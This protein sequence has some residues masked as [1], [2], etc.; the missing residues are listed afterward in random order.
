M[1]EVFGE[2]AAVGRIGGDEYL[3]Y[4]YG[5]HDDE[6]AKRLAAEVCQNL[7]KHFENKNYSV[8]S[9]IGVSVARKFIS[10][11]TMFTQADAALYVSK[12]AGKNG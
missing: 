3:A 6:A 2:D 10:Y 11:Q 8:T 12:S 9:S 7:Q 4:C 5:I 1:K